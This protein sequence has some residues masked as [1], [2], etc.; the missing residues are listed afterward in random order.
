M[1]VY[2]TAVLA[3]VVLMVVTA[4][5]YVLGVGETLELRANEELIVIQDPIHPSVGD[6]VI[7]RLR[8]GEALPVLGCEDFKSDFLVRVDLGG[9]RFG[10]VGA[11]KYGLKR[12][13]ASIRTFFR[14][15]SRLV[16]TC[17]GLLLHR[18]VD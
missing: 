14:E 4:V 2:L 18:T 6:N 8:I 12:S 11:G 3:L 15:P 17:R 10:Y 5:G 1:K 16:M 13:P 9:G 7:R